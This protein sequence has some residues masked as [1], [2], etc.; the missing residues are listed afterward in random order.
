MSVLNRVVLVAVCSLAIG[1]GCVSDGGG[2]TATGGNT[3]TGGDGLAGRLAQTRLDLAVTDAAA[4]PAAGP[5]VM[6]L[7]RDGTGDMQYGGLDL[8]YRW[9][10]EGDR[11]CLADLRLGGMASDDPSEQCA[12]VS[13]AGD[14]ITVEG[15]GPERGNRR[16]SGSISPL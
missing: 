14:R 7:R 12:A 4:D 2:G 11:L 8:T 3:A 9:R 5:M 16:M 6:R 15:L 1:S 13:I 10:A